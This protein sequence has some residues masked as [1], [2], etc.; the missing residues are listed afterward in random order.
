MIALIQRVSQASVIIEGKTF[1]Q[2]QAGL[3]ILLGVE[4]QDNETTAK[5]LL[6]R[7]LR[8][9]VFP[10]AHGKM[11][12]SVL[13][14]QG[15]VLIVP[16]FTLPADTTSGTRPSFTPA[17]EPAKGLALFNTFCDQARLAMA[18][19]V[20]QGQFGADMQVSSTNDGPVTFW[21]QTT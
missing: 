9:R 5:K 3:L 16:Q 7:V 13:Q 15:D 2:I 6:E 14:T 18:I 19:R 20:E 1:S 12:L 8:Y 11:N 10:D 4:K 21:L 17:A